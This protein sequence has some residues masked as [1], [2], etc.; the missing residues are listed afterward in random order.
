MYWI[1]YQF[2]PSV[3]LDKLEYINMHGNYFKLIEHNLGK[4][5]QTKSYLRAGKVNISSQIFCVN[6]SEDQTSTLPCMLTYFYW[7]VGSW[8]S[9]NLYGEGWDVAIILPLFLPG[10]LKKRNLKLRFLYEIWCQ[11]FM[12]FHTS[13]NG[14]IW[15]WSWYVFMTFL[16]RVVLEFTAHKWK[17]LYLW[18][19]GKNCL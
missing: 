13:C 18:A 5:Q 16:L 11:I 12:V 3:L 19:F 15:K 4:L 6:I 7:L 14:A 2:Y 10:V 1:Y 17:S 9:P 8:I